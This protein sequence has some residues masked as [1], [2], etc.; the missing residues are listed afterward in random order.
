MPKISHDKLSVRL[1]AIAD[2]HRR[3]ILRMLGERGQCSI[4]KPYGMCASDI[5]QRL[6]IAQPTISH[7]L[8]ILVGAGLVIKERVGQW[9]WFHRN[10]RELKALGREMKNL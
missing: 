4:D 10:E 6:K 7:H 1:R 5:E 8:R 2:P 9:I 3:E